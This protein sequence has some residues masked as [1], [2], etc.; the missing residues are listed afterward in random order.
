MLKHCRAKW[1]FWC[2]RGRLTRLKPWSQTWRIGLLILWPSRSPNL[3][4]ISS[5]MPSRMSKASSTVTKRAELSSARKS[6]NRKNFMRTSQL[7]WWSRRWRRCQ[8]MKR[9]GELRRNTLRRWQT[10]SGWC[11]LCSRWLKLSL[12]SSL[13]ARKQ[14]RHKTSCCMPSVKKLPKK[15]TQNGRRK[16]WSKSN[17]D[18]IYI[19]HWS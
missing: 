18:L 11:T 19:I 12:T 14:L 16:K 9:H 1:L 4:S 3:I 7:S 5:E 13:D 2:S 8:S 15:N 6:L 10:S 17:S